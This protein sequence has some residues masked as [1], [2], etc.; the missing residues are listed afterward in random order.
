MDVQY[1]QIQHHVNEFV[2]GVEIQT[3]MRVT[4]KSYAANSQEHH[5][6]PLDVASSR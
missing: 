1:E 3:D 5:L 4:T 2:V 6:Q